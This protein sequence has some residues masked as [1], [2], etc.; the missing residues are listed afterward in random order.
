[1]Y[2]FRGKTC[3]LWFECECAF[4]SRTKPGKNRTDP[5]MMAIQQRVTALFARDYV[6]AR[7][8][9][10]SGSF[11]TSYP[12]HLCIPEAQRDPTGTSPKSKVNDAKT[13]RT[14]FRNS[15]FSRVHGR[16]AC[17][18]LVIDGK[19]ICRSAT[20]AIEAETLLHNVTVKTTQMFSTL[21]A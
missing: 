16:F 1:M 11:C 15:R 19:N 14:L 6:V 4:F 17:P 7:I 8:H 21:Y 13:L 5:Q 10:E 3:V 12:L 2:L 9:N 18:V 20:I